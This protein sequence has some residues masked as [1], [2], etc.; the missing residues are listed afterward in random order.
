MPV[1][2]AF[3]PNALTG[4]AGVGPGKHILPGSSLAY[5]ID[6]ENEAS[7]SAPAQQVTI[8]DQLSSNLD[9]QTFQ[10]T[11]IGFG[12]QMIF[13]PSN[14]QHYETKVVLTCCGDPFEAQLEAGINLASGQV[15]ASFRS[16][17]PA[18]SLPPLVSIGFLPP[19]DGSGRGQGHFSYLIN[20][21]TNLPTGAQIRNVALISFDHQ[22][23]IATDQ[24]DPHDPGAGVDPNKQAFNTIDAGPPGSSVTPLPGESG[25]TFSV[26]WSGLDDSGGS[27]IQSYDV[28]VSTNS[29]GLG[30]WQEQVTNTSALFSGELGKSYAFYSIARDKVGNTESAPVVADAQTTVSTNSPI[31][32]SVTNQTIVVGLP[33][34]FTNTVLQGIPAGH[35]IF[36]LLRGPLGASVSSTNGTF[37]WTPS[38]EQGRTTNQVTVWVTDSAQTNLSDAAAFQLVVKECLRPQLGTLVLPVGGTGTLPIY[39]YS[40]EVLTNIAIKVEL[41]EGKLTASA[42]E[43]VAPEICTNSLLQIGNALYEIILSACAAPWL[44]PTQGQLVAWLYLTAASNQPSGFVYLNVGNSIGTQPDGTTVT[45][46]TTQTARVVIVGDDPLLEAILNTNKQPALVL[47]ALTGT[48]NTLESTTNMTSP[49]LWQSNQQIIMTNLQ[50]VIAPITLPAGQK[51]FRARQP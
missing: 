23:S 10:L 35:Y 41:P 49:I 5:R 17:D 11:D 40:T 36:S 46:Y 18:T 32:Q 38:C 28:F 31:L 1:S 51:Y 19:E 42:L 8:T 12:D 34:S 39:L 2:Q 45:N 29:G 30:L 20:A 3:D 14:L 50:R 21:K 26:N 22:P 43:S 7:A 27:G 47:Y 6:F 16:I 33:V 37:Q 9:W 48:T 4:P 44:Q 15:Y 24:I 13:V 25:R